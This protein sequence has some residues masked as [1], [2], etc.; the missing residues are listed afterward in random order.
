LPGFQL[1]GGLFAAEAEDLSQ[2]AIEEN[3]EYRDEE[4]DEEDSRKSEVL[5]S[6]S[7]EEDGVNSEWDLRVLDSVQQFNTRVKSF[8]LAKNSW[9]S[10]DPNRES[11]MHED[12]HPHQRQKRLLEFFIIASRLLAETKD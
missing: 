4:D 11:N 10:K 12:N 2:S 7:S 1:S 6:D 5:I 8:V 9:V 3:L